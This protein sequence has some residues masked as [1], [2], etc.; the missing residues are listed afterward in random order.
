MPQALDLP[1]EK[2]HTLLTFKEQP[3]KE[4]L[5]FYSSRYAN[6][7]NFDFKKKMQ[8]NLQCNYWANVEGFQRAN[9]QLLKKWGRLS[10]NNVIITLYISKLLLCYWISINTILPL[11]FHRTA[12]VLPRN[13]LEI[14][15]KN[16]PLP[17]LKKRPLD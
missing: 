15:C 8:R 3:E 13:F 12:G 7:Y 16:K 6:I 11:D 2:T 17:S 14:P 1:K 4:K 9:S 10:V 5:Q